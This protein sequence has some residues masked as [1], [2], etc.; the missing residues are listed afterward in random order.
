MKPRANIIVLFVIVSFLINSCSQEK[1]YHEWEDESVFGINKM[2]PHAFFLPFE[3]EA[4]AN[5]LDISSSDKYI[6][7]NGKWQF[8]FVMKPED[9]PKDFYKNDFDVSE[10]DQIDVPANWELKGYDQPH[11]LDVNYPFAKNPPFIPNDYNPVGSYKKEFIIPENWIG[12]EITLYFGAVKSAFYLWVNGQKVGYSQ[13]SKTPAEFDVTSFVKEGKNQVALEV[14]RWS[15]G[16]Y[17]EDQDFW[18]LSGI[19]RDVY[20]LKRPQT[21]VRDYFVKADLSDDY[22]TGIFSIDFDIENPKQEE[23]IFR[24]QIQEKQDGNNLFFEENSTRD[25]SIRFQCQIP[26]IKSWSAE[27]P[28][29]YQLQ[30]AT[31]SEEVEFFTQDIGFR[32]LKIEGNQFLVNGKAIKIKGVNHHEHHPVT[33]HVIS[34]ELMR[35]DIE[36]MKANN[37]N[38][39]RNSHYPNHYRWYELC[40]EYGLYVVDEANIESHGADIW[41]STYT[42]ANRP[43]WGPAHLD[44]VK[45]MLE[46]S[47]NQPCVI[48]WSLGNEAG[49]G[50]NFQDAYL[51]VKNRDASRPCQ[52]EMSQGTAYTDIEAPM[53]R[54]IQR[55]EKYAKEINK[56][57]YILCEYAHAMGNSVGNLQDYWDVIE[58]Y[59]CLQGGFIWD[60]VDQTWQMQDEEGIPFWGY[61]GDFPE[62]QVPNDSNFC[63]NGLV[64]ADRSWK[65]HLEEVKKVYQPIAFEWKDSTSNQIQITNKYDFRNLDHLNFKWEIKTE[66][67]RVASGEKSFQ[68]IKAGQRTTLNFSIQTVQENPRKEY[69]L[70]VYAIDKN[71]EQIVAREQM[72]INPKRRQTAILRRGMLKSFVDGTDKISFETQAGLK[73]E[74]DKKTGFI[75]RIHQNGIEFLASPLKPNFWRAATD[76]DLGN[77]MPARCAVWKNAGNEFVLDNIEVSEQQIKVRGHIGTIDA[78][79]ELSYT[80]NT[81]GGLDINYT[82]RTKNDS[83]PE[84]PRFGLSCKINQEFDNLSW[85]GRGPH[86]SYIDRKTSAFVDVY[87]G[88]VWDQYYPYV[89]AQENGQKMDVRWFNLLD[90]NG[91]GLHFTGHPLLSFTAH[92]FDYTA[93]YHEGKGSPNKHGSSIKKGEIISLNIDLKQMGLGGDNSWGAMPHEKYLLKNRGYDFSF[94]IGGV[95]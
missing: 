65:P 30:I 55:M 39:V 61:G 69:F 81:K 78:N 72:E 68:G 28:N 90:D 17:L 20:L 88:K 87:Q 24:V 7:L 51:W 57:P 12:N 50:V 40:N 10:W 67:G 70:N 36:L 83:L 92:H 63:A 16:S 15:D 21:H 56:K 52:Y 77:A 18:R 48:T 76:N 94:S 33:G 44:R 11:Y 41:D 54:N 53:Y 80:C 1:A 82:F 13:G 60:W 46:R 6:S 22:Q 93:L 43:S 29:L 31:S 35:R 4:L 64:N 66:D 85:F 74:V 73:I 86:E 75:D 71:T 9:R 59:D 58:E 34:E 95:Y 27:I 25:S 42:L 89:R 84:M 2:P 3:S 47:K 79:I 5:G 8:H 49:Y 26:D 37:I 19:E 38:A 14:Y 23:I 32:N 62:H 91:K 45:R